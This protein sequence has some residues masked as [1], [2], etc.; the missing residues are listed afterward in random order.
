VSIF[1]ATTMGAS[2]PW[3]V[4]DNSATA[5]AN[6][7]HRRANR[8]SLR[9]CRHGRAS[10]AQPPEG[11]KLEHD[12]FKLKH[13][14]SP[15][16]GLTGGPRLQWRAPAPEDVDGRVKP[17]QGDS[18]SQQFCGIPDTPVGQVAPPTCTELHPRDKNLH[19][20]I[21]KLAMENRL[22]PITFLYAKAVA[23]LPRS[24]CAGPWRLLEGVPC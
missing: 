3:A 17:G 7:A 16:P 9:S 12:L 20:R 13:R 10:V 8:R 19:I 5:S 11:G 1:E 2:A 14:K 6:A 4:A 18:K 21:H 15:P 22:K 23:R 24:A